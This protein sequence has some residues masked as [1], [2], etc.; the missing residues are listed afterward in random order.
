VLVPLLGPR[1][2][3]FELQGSSE[4]ANTP[5]CTQRCWHKASIDARPTDLAGLRDATNFLS[6]MSMNL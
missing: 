3:Q 1:R 6:A 5:G 4:F 2:D